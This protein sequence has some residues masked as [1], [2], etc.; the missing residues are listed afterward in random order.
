MT[1]E[2]G[3]VLPSEDLARKVLDHSVDGLLIIDAQGVV[4][5]AN[6]AAAALFARQT[7]Q[8]VGFQLGIPAIQEFV[9]MIL[10][11]GDG[12][13]Y[14]EVRSTEI[15]WAGQR[16]NLA[17]LRDVTERRRAEEAFKNQ[18]E[19][20]RVRNS[21][22]IRFNRVLVGR[23]LQMVELKQEVTALYARLGEQPPQRY[24]FV[25][26]AKFSDAASRPRPVFSKEDAY[27]RYL[28]GLLAGDS[29]TCREI[30]GLWLEAAASVH[31]I[32]QDLIQRSL[33]EVGELWAQG[34]ISVAAEHL[35]TA[36]SESLLTLAQPRLLEQPRVGKSAVVACLSRE[37]HQI[38]G[39][40][41]ADILEFNGWHSYFL[42]GN[43]PLEELKTLAE[44]KRPDVVVFSATLSSSVDYFIQAA[45]ELRAAF[46]DMPILAG[47][48]AFRLIARDRAEQVPG[49]VCLESL[50]DLQAW[51]REF[52]P[53]V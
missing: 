13:R 52:G 27:A 4:L 7:S 14:V 44:Q 29:Q 8:L 42:G 45:S 32:Y 22:L 48:Q 35:A 18:A 39:R 2:R 9:E 40:M 33:Y 5:F 25:G 51:L 26:H 41:V 3:S 46:P 34:R 50:E 31:E 6:P 19:E 28:G 10:P 12:P 37:H 30:F 49:V 21:E 1:Q 43:V 11:G 20:L 53:N 47:G 15:D 23:E 38:G 17:S 36:I 16:A 24:R